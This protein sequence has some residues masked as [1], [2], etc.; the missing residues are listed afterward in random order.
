[1]HPNFTKR[2]SNMK[3]SEKF[4]RKLIRTLCAPFNCMRTYLQTSTLHGLKYVGDWHLSYIE[5]HLLF[6][7]LPDSK[8]ILVLNLFAAEYFLP[9]PLGW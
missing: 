4:Q 8:N 5:R 6:F 7:Y 9:Y 1:M 3:K 2:S